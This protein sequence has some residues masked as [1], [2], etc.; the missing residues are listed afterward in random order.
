MKNRFAFAAA[1]LLAVAGAAQAQVVYTDAVG[2]VTLPDGNG[3]ANWPHTDIQSVEISNTLS[4][5]SFKFN[6]VGD[7]A[8]T[9]WAK[10][11]VLINNL[12]NTN[13]VAGNGWG[14]P[15]EMFGGANAWVGSWADSGGGAEAYTNGSGFGT[16]NSW[17][18]TGKTYDL[19]GD[20]AAPGLS[21]A[22]SQF[23]TTITVPLSLLGLAVGDMFLFDAFTTGGGGGD[24]AWDS[25]QSATPSVTGYG[26]PYTAFP[27]LSYTVVPAPGSAALLAIGGLVAARRRRA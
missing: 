23:S 4:S 12:S 17:S 25:L 9:N 1:G 16:G 10:Y 20:P 26:G 27:I 14:R 8:A 13:T 6:I 18:R 19:P 11:T 3:S 24:S 7:I 22:L 5:I 15:I 2:E 21:V